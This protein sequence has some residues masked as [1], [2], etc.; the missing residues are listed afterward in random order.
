MEK[1]KLW[2]KRAMTYWLIAW[3]MVRG[4]CKTWLLSRIFAG[5]GLEGGKFA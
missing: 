1:E 4:L 3:A 2:L 5:Q